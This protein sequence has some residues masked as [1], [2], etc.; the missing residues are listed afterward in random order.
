MQVISGFAEAS[1]LADGNPDACLGACQHLLGEVPQDT[2]P[3]E[4][5]IRAGNV[6]ALIVHVYSSQNAWPQAQRMLEEM[7]ARG[8]MAAAFLD[9]ALLQQ[10]YA[11]VGMQAPAGQVA[12]GD[13][14][15]QEDDADVVSE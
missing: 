15:V 12:R 7:D 2:T 6:Y 3:G 5:C 14:A 8:I 11:A 9:S 4:A 1:A 10:V 13:V